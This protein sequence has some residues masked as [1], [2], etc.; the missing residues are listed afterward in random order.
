[1]NMHTRFRWFKCLV[2]TMQGQI[3]VN[4]AVRS[5]QLTWVSWG[6]GMFWWGNIPLWWLSQRP[7][8]CHLG[9]RE[10][11]GS[12]P[13]RKSFPKI[14]WRALRKWCIIGSSFLK[15]QQSMGNVTLQ[16]WG[17]SLRLNCDDWT[18]RVTLSSSTTVLLASTLQ[19]CD[20]SWMSSQT[21]GSADNDQLLGHFVHLTCPH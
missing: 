5:R 10:I 6:V 14:V 7:Q 12:L 17:S 3:F 8:L 11:S 16:C 2:T 4:V 19:M 1:M 13:T 20:S 21:S 15:K 9:N 18:C